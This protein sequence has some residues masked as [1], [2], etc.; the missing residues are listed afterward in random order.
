MAGNQYRITTSK[1]RRIIA[2]RIIDDAPSEADWHRLGEHA[3]LHSQTVLMERRAYKPD[4]SWIGN[5]YDV[6]AHDFDGMP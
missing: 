5:W 6:A 1:D 4:L 3:Q 2:Q